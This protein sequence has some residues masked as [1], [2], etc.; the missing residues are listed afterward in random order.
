MIGSETAALVAGGSLSD[1][2]T[3]LSGSDT[4][5]GVAWRMFSMVK[6][7]GGRGDGMRKVVSYA[8]VGSL[9]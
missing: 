7:K 1:A 8:V 6:I 9:S 4:W 3:K 5:A 2:K